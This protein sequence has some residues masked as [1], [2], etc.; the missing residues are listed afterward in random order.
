MLQ[1]GWEQNYTPVA[2]SILWS[3]CLAAIPIAVLLYV[4]GVQRI[5]AW[6]ASIAGLAAAIVMAAIVYRMPP[7]LIFD[8]ALYGAAFGVF[9]IFWIVYWAIFLYRVTVETG[10]FEIIKASIGHL[11]ANP[12]LQALLIAF[13]FGAFLEGA[14]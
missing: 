11:T 6:K 13:A 3:A 5:A 8:S 7:S 14:A 4:I 2:G 1:H 10:K 12:D 9:P